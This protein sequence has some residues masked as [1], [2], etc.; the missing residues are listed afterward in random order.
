MFSSRKKKTSA[1]GW[2]VGQ[3]LPWMFSEQAHNIHLQHIQSYLPTHSSKSDRNTFWGFVTCELHISSRLTNNMAIKNNLVP[4]A[5]ERAKMKQRR[6]LEWYMHLQVLSG[7]FL[8]ASSRT[9]KHS[10]F[11]SMLDASWQ[12]NFVDAPFLPSAWWIFK[13]HLNTS[14][15]FTKNLC[16]IAFSPSLQP[17]SNHSQVD[18]KT[19]FFIKQDLSLAGQRDSNLT[20][21]YFL[22]QSLIALK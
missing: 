13:A 1:K 5:A 10:S 9:I 14:S 7:D 3:S 17:L 21:V 22:Y 6:N 8:I 15:L 18:S 16:Q 11:Y 2:A 20:I 4:W 12:D 19:E